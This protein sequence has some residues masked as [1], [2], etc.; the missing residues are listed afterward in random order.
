MADELKPTVQDLNASV[1]FAERGIVSKTLY[2]SATTKITLMCFEP[3]QA[4]SEHQA[5]F[6]AII[7]VLQGSADFKL[8]DKVY[9]AKAGAL[10]VM[11]A[12]LAHAVT[13]KERFVFVLTMVR[14]PAPAKIH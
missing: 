11:P 5:P 4:L 9:D 13:A 14:A 8:G 10:Y 12:G 2:E 6:E 7:Q 3:G 1:Q